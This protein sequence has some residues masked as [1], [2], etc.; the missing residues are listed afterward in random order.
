MLYGSVRANQYLPLGWVY[1]DVL[2]VVG[3]NVT[4]CVRVGCTVVRTNVKE[5]GCVI[6][7]EQR[8]GQTTQLSVVR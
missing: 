6:D 5:H 7:A 3:C 8:L 2:S 4:I 1:G